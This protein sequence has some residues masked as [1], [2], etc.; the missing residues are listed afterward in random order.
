MYPLPR[1]R[2]DQVEPTDL[3]LLIASY[4][5]DATV[6]HFL[7]YETADERIAGFLRLSLPHS[8]QA[9][10]LPELAGHAMIRSACVWAGAA[11]RPND[12]RR[13]AAQWTWFPTH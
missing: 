12:R 5:T 8:D 10:P 11:H 1:I 2:R 13:R 3:Q 7:S 6:E 9:L 4:D